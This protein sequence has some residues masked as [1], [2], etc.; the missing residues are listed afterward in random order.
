MIHNSKTTFPL[1]LIKRIYIFPKGPRGHLRSVTALQ[2]IKLWIEHLPTF[3][4]MYRIAIVIGDLIGFW[5]FLNLTHRIII[6]DVLAHRAFQKYTTCIVF[7]ECLRKPNQPQSL[8]VVTLI[9]LWQGDR[10]WPVSGDRQIFLSVSA[11]RAFLQIF[12]TKN[13]VFY[14]WYFLQQNHC[15]LESGWTHKVVWH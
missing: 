4:L 5:I 7:R 9:R 3:V 15:S 8:T 12:V 14:N 11:E 10:S 13:I 1:K 6:F 2:M